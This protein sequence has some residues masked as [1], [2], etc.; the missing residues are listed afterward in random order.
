[1]NTLE[2][3][4]TS[5]ATATA[6][7]ESNRGGFLRRL[8]SRQQKKKKQAEEDGDEDATRSF[9]NISSASFDS[10][11]QIPLELLKKIP[12]ALLKKI[13]L[14]KKGKKIPE[15]N[16][17][18]TEEGNSDDDD[19]RKIA[20]LEENIEMLSN[21]CARLEAQNILV[22]VQKLDL[23]ARLIAI[24]L[25]FSCWCGYIWI[26]HWI[27]RSDRVLIPFIL[28]KYD[29]IIPFCQ[30]I[31][32]ALLGLGFP[33]MYHKRRFGVTH[34]R[35]E[36]FAV[37]FFV[38]SRTR[39]AKWRER[40]FVNPN[41]NNTD[42]SA[43][44]LPYGTTHDEDALWD[45]NYEVSARFL[46]VS[47]LRLKGLWTKSAQY[48]SSRA[49]FVPA[50]YV[51][52]LR[53]LQDEAPCTP[54]EDVRIP[55]H[56][57]NELSD[58]STDPL[59]SASIGQVHLASLKKNGQK[60]VVKVQHPCSQTL[61]SDD[62]WS[63]K[64]IAR[65][66]AWM[67]P[68]WQFFEILMTEWAQEAQ[69]ELDFMAEA[70][71]L[72]MARRSI[73][74]IFSNNRVLHTNAATANSSSKVPFRVEIPK[75]FM[76]LTCRHVMVM[77]FCE[78]VRIDDFDYIKKQGL[79]QAAIMDG[80]AQTFAH[81]M[82]ISDIFNG[83]PHPGNILLRSGIGEESTGKNNEGGFTLSLLDWG[84]AK[85]LP[86]VKRIA[87][88]QMVY[89]ASTY[90]FGLLLDAFHTIGL[91][92]KRENVAE[93][94]EGMRFLLRD[95][96]PSHISRNRIKAKIKTDKNRM[97]S[98]KKGE[99]I[100]IDSKAYP[101]EFFFF[102]R[103]NELLHGLGSSMSVSMSY[104]DVLA[105]YAKRGLLNSIATEHQQ[106]N[107]TPYEDK[108]FSIHDEELQQKLE[109]MV[110]ASL[111]SSN[112]NGGGIQICVLD[113]NAKCL[114]H[115]T[116]GNLGGLYQSESMTPST[117]ILGFSCTKAITAT[118]A[119]LLVQDD[120]LQYDDYVYRIWNN[121]CPTDTA[122]PGLAVA[123]GLSKEEV[124]ERWT[125]KRQITLRHIL[126]HQAGFGMT[127]PHI[128]TI[129]K[130]ASSEQCIQAMEYSPNNE[131]AT[132][133]PTSKPGTTTEYHFLSFG[134]LVAGV[135][136]AAYD[137]K[138]KNTRTTNDNLD[139][140]PTTF[141]HVYEDVLE[142]KLSRET[143]NWGFKPCGLEATT[144]HRS[145][146]QVEASDLNTSILIQKQREMRAMGEEESEDVLRAMMESSSS[147]S[148]MLSSFRGKEFLL[149]PRI[150]NCTDMLKANVPA[151]GGRFSARGLA[152]F[153]HDLSTLKILDS[154]TLE[155]ATTLD[156]SA[157]SVDS[158]FQGITSLMVEKRTPQTKE[159]KIESGFG[160]GYQVYP[161]SDKDDCYGH[162][163]IGGSIGVHHKKSGLSIA[164]MT[165]KSNNSGSPGETI[166]KFMNVIREHYKF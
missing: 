6:T 10:E 129:Q 28:E 103:V 87:F 66:V 81:M 29:V 60:V 121:F 56:I 31:I 52:E 133:L 25:S 165:N 95:M 99:K 82:Y 104:L 92:L 26:V 74:E 119:H 49:D 33:I 156:T 166:L 124:Q 120:F 47:I 36:V 16:T 85:R 147:A 80:V 137:R 72:L 38:I 51:R 5:A 97:D 127:L 114:A 61:I 163:G 122:P 108:Y 150:W 149:D 159:Q 160:L 39:L 157:S 9:S 146:A 106:P 111:L 77:S 46:Y 48:L 12:P 78:G 69:K 71:N 91:K 112:D 140:C 22:S 102:V 44:V 62:F 75:P 131:E 27:V 50:A 152:K 115:V 67:D 40:M 107:K 73:E 88:C 1:M 53:R 59:A 110:G 68:E 21:K 136:C 64:V 24:F 20:K 123:L 130:L 142:R 151:A 158:R 15:L 54:W 8:S 32:T 113:K 105:P 79:D 70:S 18:N 98:R 37:A 65:L 41:N 125:W 14:R 132:L 135:V 128:L 138:K 89:A 143:I 153:Y 76:E 145:L 139:R 42:D 100:P 154:S 11:D 93:D 101:G 96:A 83:D 57:L 109:S 116:K 45:A 161:L 7:T 17:N 2:K 55:P 34:R 58:I 144:Q 126:Q 4:S 43:V 164:I 117:L 90:D 162:A 13:A 3:K 118:L 63:L 35:F 155:L 134:W 148:S 23:A 94:L 19:K 30:H 141:K 86:T 84:L